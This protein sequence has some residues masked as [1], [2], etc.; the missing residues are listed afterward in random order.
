MGMH[1]ACWSSGAVFWIDRGMH[2][3]YWSPAAVYIHCNVLHGLLREKKVG[4]GFRKTTFGWLWRAWPRVGIR[5]FSFM[6]GISA[7]LGD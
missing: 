5:A 4:V 2:I 7:G 6:E 3:A 1:T